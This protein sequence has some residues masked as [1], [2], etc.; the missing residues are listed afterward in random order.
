MCVQK[1][2]A[3][4]GNLYRHVTPP[5]TAGVTDF[6]TRWAVREQ[7]AVFPPGSADFSPHRGDVV[8][9]TFSHIGIVDTVGSG[10]VTTIEGNTNQAG[11]R[12]GTHVLNKT[13]EFDRIRCFIRMPVPIAYDTTNNVCRLPEAAE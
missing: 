5:R 10:S 4:Q 2:V 1:F 6:R 8:V 13:R 11:S 9:F 3:A 7:C 12:E